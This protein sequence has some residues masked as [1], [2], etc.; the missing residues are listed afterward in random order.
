MVDGPLR[1]KTA[2]MLA[3]G[4]IASDQTGAFPKVSNRGHKYITVFYVYDAK[5]VR[6]VPV[7]SRHRQD[8]LRAHKDV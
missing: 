7:K 8:L 6:G 1:K 2:L 4:K 5:F 3:D